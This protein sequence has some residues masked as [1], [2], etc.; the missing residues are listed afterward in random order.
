MDESGESVSSR[1]RS[2]LQSR[3]ANPLLALTAFVAAILVCS[4]F[5]ELLL[6]TAFDPV[7]VLD[8]DAMHELRWR[9]MRMDAPP[10][11]G[12][13]SEY[14]YDRFD[15]KLGW[16]PREGYDAEGVRTNSAGIRADREFQVPKPPGVSRV[17][18]LG[19]SFVWGEE[20]SNEDAFVTRLDAKMA[21][22]EAVNLGV[23]GYGTG[24]QLLR[25]R[26][27]GVALE[28]DLVLLGF[29]E[30]DL[31]RNVLA[32]RD[33][34]KPV[35]RL[36]DDE[37][38]LENVPVPA[39]DEVLAVEQRLPA[40]F[41]LA[42]LK[43]GLRRWLESSVAGLER[44]EAWRVS[45][46]ILDEAVRVSRES[47]ARF[48][49]VYIPYERLDVETPLEVLLERWARDGRIPYLSLRQ[50]FSALPEEERGRL[51]RGHWT[52][53]GNEVVA[54]IVERFIRSGRM[55]ALDGAADGGP[56]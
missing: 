44:S 17:V 36:R 45:R 40:S 16:V 43:R 47:G 22:A 37:L 29:Y 24:Q 52:P 35:F 14:G 2:A 8:G 1:K 49:L 54:D 12:V 30:G 53:H 19:D 50:E 10:P 55:L 20:V 23:H 34:A 5:G 41:F 6:R 48:G 42:V 28:P 39:P 4:A 11:G 18:V 46:A 13:Q 9:R 32:F 26:E 51:Y 21:G 7:R 27:L 56:E 25:L 3:F 33:Y 15:Q 38:V 31:S